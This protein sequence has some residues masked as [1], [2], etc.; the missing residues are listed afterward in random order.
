MLVTFGL[1]TS[2]L[3]QTVVKK[4]PSHLAQILCTS[5][6]IN[7]DDLRPFEGHND[8]CFSMLCACGTVPHQLF[9]KSNVVL[10]PWWYT[11]KNGTLIAKRWR[12]IMLYKQI[13]IPRLRDHLRLLTGRFQHCTYSDT[14]H[15]LI[16]LFSTDEKSSETSIKSE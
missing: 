1:F 5:A 13:F 4:T 12:M 9:T 6:H 14:L 2:N 16:K 7:R 11:K 8:S 15:S 3:G 10:S